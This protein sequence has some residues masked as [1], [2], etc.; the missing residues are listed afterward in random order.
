MIRIQTQKLTIDNFIDLVENWYYED[1]KGF[2]TLYNY[3]I[4]NVK[5]IPVGTNPD[6][7]YL[8]NNPYVDRLEN[9][10]KFFK[11][12]YNWSP[13]SHS[14]LNYIQ[15]FSW[16]YYD[17]QSGLDFIRTEPGYLMTKYFVELEGQKMDSLKSLHI[18]D[19]WIQEI[20]TEINQYK[21]PDGGFKS[22]NEFFSRELKVPRSVSSQ[23]DD[24]VVVA[25]VDSIINMIKNELSI[26]KPIQV[27][28]QKLSLRKL[29]CDS[30]F[31]YNFEGGTAVSCVLTP[32]V[33]HRYHAPVSGI[34][35][36]TREDVT[37]QYFGI[38]DFPKLLNQ[39]N[40]G[41]AYDYSVFEHFRR[42]YIIIKT[43]NYGYVAMIPVGLNNISSVVFKEKFKNVDDQN[44]I[45]IKKGEEIGYFQYGGSLNI[46]LFEKN[47]FPSIR[48]PQGQIIGTLEKKD[49]F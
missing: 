7:I 25:P 12:W 36:E 35:V 11:E 47:R 22:F 30:K 27:K 40:V 31:I 24:S 15:K 43:R 9:L 13:N 17:N 29:L 42:G 5:S 39:G 14:S 41:L 49:K 26:D 32:T 8:W 3:A 20:G 33:Y 46:L 28:T 21:I 37:G 44:P 18:V 6:I 38:K 45:E 10:T 1:Y 34:V 4:E 19:K 48:I 23:D 16:L 2:R